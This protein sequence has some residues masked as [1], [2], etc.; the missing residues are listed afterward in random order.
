MTEARAR[1]RGRRRGALVV[2]IPVEVPFEGGQLEAL[3]ELTAY[4]IGLR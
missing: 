3:P 4:S 1:R 2:N